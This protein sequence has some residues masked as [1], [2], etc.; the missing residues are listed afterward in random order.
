M[1]NKIYLL[2]LAVSVV[3]MSVVAYLTY[4]QLMSIGFAPAVIV[5]SFNTYSSAYWGFLGVSFI[6]LLTVGNIILWK[7]RTSWALWTSLGFFVI[8]VLLKSFWLG[9]ELFDYE[10]RSAVPHSSP[11]VTY[12]LGVL[13][14]AAA[15]AAVFFNHFLVLRMRDKIHGEPAMIDSQNAAILTEKTESEEI[16]DKAVTDEKQIGDDR[17]K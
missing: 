10:T 12:F 11:F 4:S 9:K 16:F 7:F 3:V 1:W 2:L 6:I 5:G 8:F 13:L 17:V 15:A 14:C